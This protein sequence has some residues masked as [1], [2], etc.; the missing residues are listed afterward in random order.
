M[1]GRREVGE[2]GRGMGEGERGREIG[3]YIGGR[4]KNL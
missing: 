3:R 2:V 1:E 4:Q